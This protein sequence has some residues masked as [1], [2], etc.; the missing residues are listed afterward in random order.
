MD[1]H[2]FKPKPTCIEAWSEPKCIEAWPEPCKNKQFQPQVLKA[3]DL[4]S[5]GVIIKGQPVNEGYPI[6]SWRL[7]IAIALV[8]VLVLAGLGGWLLF[9]EERSSGASP[10]KVGLTPLNPN[11]RSSENAPD[12]AAEFA[13]PQLS[14]V[15]ALQVHDADSFAQDPRARTAIKICLG[16]MLGVKRG[17]V[18]LNIRRSGRSL[19]GERRLASNL[20]V[21]YTVDLQ[22]GNREK[23]SELAERIEFIRPETM[24]LQLAND[25]HTVGMDRS[26]QVL[27]MTSSVL[28]TQTTMLPAASLAAEYIPQALTS[29]APSQVPPAAIPRP[30]ISPTATPRQPDQGHGRRRRRKHA[31]YGQQK[32]DASTGKGDGWQGGHSDHDSPK[33]GG[34]D[35]KHDAMRGEEAEKSSFPRPK[36]NEMQVNGGAKGDRVQSENHNDNH[37][38]S[39]RNTAKSNR[40]QGGTA[41]NG[42]PKPG[43]STGKGDRWQ[44]GKSGHHGPKLGDRF[45]EPDAKRDEEVE[46]IS[47]PRPKTSET[48]GSVKGDRIQNSGKGDRMQGGKADSGWSKPDA[49]TGRGGGKSHHNWQKSAQEY[50]KTGWNEGGKGGKGKGAR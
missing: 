7:V 13:M 45:D 32:P 40:M 30:Q 25:L 1:K 6:H 14:G 11:A 26:V 8:V 31:A 10:Q 17:S 41:D 3:I 38:R 12:K 18:H 19:R 23:A 4:D 37:P 16:R 29:A 36:P 15:L 50:D 44:S 20:E 34:H 21:D 39:D 24:S 49:N 47:H 27:R 33:P 9:M 35:D 5:K 2:V 43:A 22:E 48:G 42:S 46:E 28:M